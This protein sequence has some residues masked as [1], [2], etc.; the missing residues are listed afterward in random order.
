MFI[1]RSYTKA[2]YQ[3]EN[4]EN[5][6]E[7]K[8]PAPNGLLMRLLKSLTTLLNYKFF[9]AFIQFLFYYIVNRLIRRRLETSTSKWYKRSFNL[10]TNIGRLT[11]WSMA[12][13]L[14]VTALNYGYKWIQVVRAPYGAPY[15]LSFFRTDDKVVPKDLWTTLGQTTEENSISFFNSPPIRSGIT[16][17]TW[18]SS[19]LVFKVIIV[20][21]VSVIFYKIIRLTG[22]MILQF[23]HYIFDWVTPKSLETLKDTVTKHTTKCEQEIRLLNNHVFLIDKTVRNLDQMGIINKETAEMLGRLSPEAKEIKE[24]S[25]TLMEAMQRL[26]IKVNAM[27]ER[28]DVNRAIISALMQLI[29]DT[30]AKGGNKNIMETT[31][32]DEESYNRY[33]KNAEAN[34]PLFLLRRSLP[35]ALRKFI[36]P[37]AELAMKVETITKVLSA[38]AGRKISQDEQEFDDDNDRRLRERMSKEKGKEGTSKG[39]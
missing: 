21:V 10:L 20:I 23:L 12:L 17:I 5:D 24:R 15:G 32:L 3:S 39:V 14:L 6:N 2:T 18:S 33:L 4:V 16:G 27:S 38:D 1:Y 19:S 8:P 35:Y 26:N 36:D 37:N 9:V 28:E 25:D 34:T 30:Q 29:Q 7:V 13:F 11:N 31:F 22:I